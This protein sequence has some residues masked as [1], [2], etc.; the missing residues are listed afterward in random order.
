MLI[1]LRFPVLSLSEENIGTSA[2]GT[3]SGFHS[4][5]NKTTDPT[6]LKNKPNALM[7]F[8][9]TTYNCPSQQKIHKKY[10]PIS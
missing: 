3:S 4:V 2:A 5:Q 10:I 9:F 8:P 6:R 7:T 1:I